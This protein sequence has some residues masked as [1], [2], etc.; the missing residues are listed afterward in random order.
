M[1]SMFRD[2][3]RREGAYKWPPE[4]TIVMNYG[5]AFSLDTTPTSKNMTA[6]C[7]AECIKHIYVSEN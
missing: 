3:K 6:V 7:K 1:D 5:H 2:S 4:L